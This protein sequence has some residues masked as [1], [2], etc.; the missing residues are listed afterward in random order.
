VGRDRLVDVATYASLLLLGVAL[1]VYGAFLVPLRLFGGVE[2][3]ADVIGFGGVLLAGVLG[4]AGSARATAAVTPGIG[5]VVAV[6]A[7]GTS[8]GGDVVVPGS[9]G[10][11]PGVGIVGSLYLLSGLAGTLAAAIVVAV[12]R[13]RAAARS[14]QHPQRVAG[15][16]RST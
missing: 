12:R 16:G 6:V 4:A 5:W 10:N 8:T 15:F 3:L 13:R 2:G 11:D 14:T 9:L 7:L 1:G